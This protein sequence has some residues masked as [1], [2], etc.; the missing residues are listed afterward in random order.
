MRGGETGVAEIVVTSKTNHTREVL[1]NGISIPDVMSLT[2][3][4]EPNSADTA[5]LYI[6]SD[7]FRTVDEKLEEA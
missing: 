2:L 1:V 4:I 5:V 7:K 3:N 6:R